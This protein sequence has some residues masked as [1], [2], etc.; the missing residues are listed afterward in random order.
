MTSS[1]D[2][3]GCSLMGWMNSVGGAAVLGSRIQLVPFWL[4]SVPLVQLATPLRL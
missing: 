3:R 1:G 2:T 4:L